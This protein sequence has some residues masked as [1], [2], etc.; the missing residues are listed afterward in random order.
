M[1]NDR[2]FSELVNRAKKGDAHAFGLVYGEIAEDAYRFAYYYT[3]NPHNAED[4]I[5]ETCLKA[6]KKL[7]ELKKPEAFRSWFFKILSNICKTSLSAL[8]I[9]VPTDSF[10]D[11]AAEDENTELKIEMRELLS[12]LTSEDR[13]IVL[14]SV[15]AGFSSR[16][17]AHMSG[18][19]ANT[20]RSRLSRALAA[21]RKEMSTEVQTNETAI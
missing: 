16:E 8:K 2:D 20:V 19:N 12:R 15:V 1:M 9:V 3:K 6:W 17:I 10:P 7:P 5:Q 18:M 11:T 13:Q 14:L 21:L 4:A